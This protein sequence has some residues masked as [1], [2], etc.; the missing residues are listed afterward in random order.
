MFK[1]LFNG[2][3]PV[4]VV[5]LVPELLTR[6][7]EN[8]KRYQSII[9]RAKRAPYWGVKSRFRVIYI[10][11]CVCRGPKSVGGI[12]WAKH[13]HAQS[14]YWAVN[15]TSDTRIIHLDYTLEQL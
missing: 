1:E 9:G 2:P 7:L 6:L 13:A 3:T 8:S 11:A 14:Q 4:F 10:C 15:P 5:S 12:T